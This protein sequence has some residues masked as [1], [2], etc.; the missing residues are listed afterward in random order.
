MLSRGL[1]PTTI[2][3]YDIKLYQFLTSSVLWLD[4]LREGVI[5][6]EWVTV[7]WLAADISTNKMQLEI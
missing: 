1:S 5:R 2:S 4:L 6:V 3:A 7:L